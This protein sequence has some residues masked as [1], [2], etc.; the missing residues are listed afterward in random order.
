MAE[1]RWTL[2]KYHSLEGNVSISSVND[3]K[4]VVDLTEMEEG[5]REGNPIS[6]E[7]QEIDHVKII[8]EEAVAEATMMVAAAIQEVET[9]EDMTEAVM[10][11]AAEALMIEV[12]VATL[13]I[14]EVEVDM[15]TGLH[16]TDLETDSKLM[17]HP[18]ETTEFLSNKNEN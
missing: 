15:K 8:M 11:V 12:V 1:P 5:S 10:E 2:K 4:G 7:E 16:R 3:S 6:L 17:D 9:V 14:E 13:V 18:E